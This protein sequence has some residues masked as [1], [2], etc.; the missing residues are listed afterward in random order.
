M[1][2][3]TTVHINN[4]QLPDA[5]DARKVKTTA[6]GLPPVQVVYDACEVFK[7]L[8]NPTRLR[9][10]HALTHEELCVGDLARALELAMSALSHQLALLR[11]MRLIA[12]RDEGRQTFY[13]VHDHFVGSLVHACL[14]H[15]EHDQNAK[16]SG[17]RHPHE[18]RLNHK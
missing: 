4:S 16:G 6:A 7:A 12:A 18:K 9:I 17:H 8:T 13:R 15:V 3:S 14:A 1:K 5:F 11:R 2:V 10:M